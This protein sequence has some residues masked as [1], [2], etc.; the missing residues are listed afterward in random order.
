MVSTSGFVQAVKVIT[1]LSVILWKTIVSTMEVAAKR[2]R[3]AQAVAR[4]VGAIHATI[5]FAR[6]VSLSVTA[7][8]YPFAEWNAWN[9]VTVAGIR[10]EA[11]TGFVL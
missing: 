8:T 7:A 2:N 3:P 5:L 4:P 1:A 6:I 9:A 10:Y 11:W